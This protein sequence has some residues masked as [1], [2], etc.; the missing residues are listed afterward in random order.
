MFNNYKT[1]V[2][3]LKGGIV[4]PAWLAS[5]LETANNIGIESVSFGARQQLLIKIYDRE[6]EFFFRK[7][8]E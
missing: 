6:M 5:V 7:K 4:A 8:N 3:N 1:L 2:I